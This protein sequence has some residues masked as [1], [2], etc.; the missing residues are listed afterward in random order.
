EVKGIICLENNTWRNLVTKI[1]PK[2]DSSPSAPFT[3][4]YGDVKIF[5]RSIEVRKAVEVLKNLMNKSKI[6]LPELE[7]Y[8]APTNLTREQISEHEVSKS[9][10]EYGGTLLEWP[11]I[12][13]TSN[14]LSISNSLLY[15]PLINPNLPFY[16]Y[17]E[18]AI[19]KEVGLPETYFGKV[20]IIVPDY[21]ARIRLV[22]YSRKR[23]KVELDAKLEKLE[24]LLCKYFCIS[25]KEKVYQGEIKFEKPEEEVEFEDEVNVFYFYLITKEGEIIDYKEGT[26]TGCLLYPSPGI[27]IEPSQEFV[28]SIIEEGENEH[29]EFKKEIPDNHREFVESIVAFANKKGG[30]VLLGVDDNCNIV[31]ATGRDLDKDRIYDIVRD[32]C[33]P[34]PK[35][36]IK[37]VKA[38]GKKIVLINVKE[39]EDKPYVVKGKGPYIRVG[40]SDRI[41]TRIEL[42]QIYNTK[43]KTSTLFSY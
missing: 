20:V 38:R 21:R 4:N 13:Y 11:S 3:Y 25:K 43:G 17:L 40:S 30:I 16:P 35:I 15:K 27:S 6:S 9:Y 12:L 8:E 28:E 32:N 5:S 24:N 26:Y 2:A 29:V 1:Y 37:R 23:I 41:M 19:R 36:S 10:H 31:G 42:D 7:E 18:Y 33:E 14:Q 34:M 22:L 39:G